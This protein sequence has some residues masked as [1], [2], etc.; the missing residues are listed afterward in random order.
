[1]GIKVKEELEPS[2]T[3]NY[4]FVNILLINFGDF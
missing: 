2:E 3:T 1:M 4:K